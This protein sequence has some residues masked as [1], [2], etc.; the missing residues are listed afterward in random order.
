M[1]VKQP[2]TAVV[3]TVDKKVAIDVAVP[4][5]NIRKKNLRKQLER[6]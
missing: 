1:K 4:N 3:D 2:I 6:M 5:N